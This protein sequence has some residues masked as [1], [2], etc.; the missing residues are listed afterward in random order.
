MSNN[1]GS[2]PT[3]TDSLDLGLP[4]FTSAAASFVLYAL[5][6]VALVDNAYDALKGV[7]KGLNLLAQGKIKLPELP[8]K[9]KMPL[10]LG[11]G[12]VSGTVT[13]GLTRLLSV[14]TERDCQCEAASFFV[15]YSLGLPCFAFRPNSL[16][17]VVMIFESIRGNE[18]DAKISNIDPLLS[19]PGILKILIWLMAPVA[20]ESMKHPQLIS[21]DP[22]EAA[23]LLKRLEKTCADRDIDLYSIMPLIE[24]DQELVLRWAYQE[25]ESM[26]LRNRK[27]CDELVERL[28]GGAATVGDCVA[29]ME[30]W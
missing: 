10:G 30:G 4:A 26:L 5:G 24:D 19:S 28:A 21:S 11:T 2:G 17:A 16:E 20:A 14:D 8:D 9:D 12:Q 18:S 1:V 23:G 29:V 27:V 3:L 25:A 13:A 7:G 6:T 22:R 15:A